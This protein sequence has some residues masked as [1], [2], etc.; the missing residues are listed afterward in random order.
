MIEKLQRLKIKYQIPLVGEE[1]NNYDTKL[2]EIENKI[3]NTTSLVMETNFNT[4]LKE[5]IMP[6]NKIPIVSTFDKNL[7][8]FSIRISPN[9][10]KPVEAAK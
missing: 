3:P 9:K 7:N 4:K 8:I 5:I 6:E 2:G 10:V 1:K